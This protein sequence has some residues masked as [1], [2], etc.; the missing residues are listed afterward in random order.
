MNR[1][2]TR[3]ATPLNSPPRRG[4][5]SFINPAGVEKVYKGRARE[6]GRGVGDSRRKKRDG[7]LQGAEESDSP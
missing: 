2:L 3:R 5:F 6:R 4:R 1:V 7:V